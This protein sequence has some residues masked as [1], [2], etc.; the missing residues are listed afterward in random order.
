MPV[1]ALNPW[2]TERWFYDYTVLGDQHSLMMRTPDTLDAASAGEQIDAFLS[3][4]EGGLIEI[5]TVGLRVARAGSNIT[6]NEGT[7]GLAATYGTGAGSQINA[8]LQVTFVGRSND[9]HKAR[10][11]IFGWDGQTDDSWR[12]TVIEN[13]DVAAGVTFLQAITGSGF[14]TS[15]SGEP[16]VWH[17]YANIGYNDHWVKAAR[18]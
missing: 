6:N 17:P 10:V 4:I 14:F 5:T 18:G 3:A 8:P 11:G 7:V 1:T 12:M 15:I 2:N 13:A 9:G 16:V